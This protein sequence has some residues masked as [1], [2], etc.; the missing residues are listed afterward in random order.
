MLN[1]LLGAVQVIVRAATSGPSDASGMK[2]WIFGT[3]AVEPSTLRT[4]GIGF[5]L[6]VT[7][8]MVDEHALFESSPTV[9]AS[10]L[11]HNLL[12]GLKAHFVPE[13]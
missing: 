12:H 6:A 1:V 11:V 13:H 10:H 7:V 3:R 5:Q 8:G 4:T 2:S 9:W